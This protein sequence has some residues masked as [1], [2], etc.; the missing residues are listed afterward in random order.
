MP[1]T[2]SAAKELRK[3]KVRMARNK[4]IKDDLKVLI[5]K[6]NKASQSGD[7]QK[8]LD[9]TKKLQ[10]LIDKAARKKIIK[11]N[12]AARKKSRLLKRIKSDTK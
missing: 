1:I 8:T 9:L 10:S 5:K 2:K 12:A 7:K 3:S 11:K 4:R 6:I